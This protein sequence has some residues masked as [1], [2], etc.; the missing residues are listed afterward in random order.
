MSAADA[1]HVVHFYQDGVDLCA[2]LARFMIEGVQ[3]RERPIVLTTHRNWAAVCDTLTQSGH[4]DVF[5][6]STFVDAEAVL[7]DASSD[8]R[9]DTGRF[10][11]ALERVIAQAGQRVRLFGDVVNLLAARGAV[12]YETAELWSSVRQAMRLEHNLP[13]VRD[14]PKGSSPPRRSSR[15]PSD[16]RS[17]S[18]R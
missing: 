18:R 3:L 1:E 8:G 11:A 9:V 4:A 16:R 10:V 2:T 15:L 12:E 17:A 6:K 14:E 7:R 5:L 13:K